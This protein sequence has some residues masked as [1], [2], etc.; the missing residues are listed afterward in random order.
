MR[1]ARKKK[2]ADAPFGR[3]SVRNFRL[4]F[5]PS[6]QIFEFTALAL[7][8]LLVLIDLLVLVISG[9]FPSLQLI[10]DQCA[11]AQTQ[12]RADRCARARMAYRRADKTAGRGAAKRAD[13]GTL[14][15]S[16]QRP[17]RATRQQSGD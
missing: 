2:G 8:L 6:S 12:C 17:A 10:A 14:L 1:S 13:P 4:V 15:T 16:G 5:G 7:E 9:I 11:R 3:K